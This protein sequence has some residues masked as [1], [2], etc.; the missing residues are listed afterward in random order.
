MAEQKLPKLMT[1]VRFPSP[2]PVVA[3]RAGGFFMPRNAYGAN[4]TPDTRSASYWSD[5]DKGGAR[6]LSFRFPRKR[7]VVRQRFPGPR[8][9][10]A[11]RGADVSLRPAGGTPAARA[12]ARSDGTRLEEAPGS[13]ARGRARR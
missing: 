7:F 9:L 13:R 12:A 11:R 10:R 8:E 4:R 1:R 2:A 3:A 6:E 5:P